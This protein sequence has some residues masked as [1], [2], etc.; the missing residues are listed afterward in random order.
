M[1]LLVTLVLGIGLAACSSHPGALSDGGGT[2]GGS[3]GATNPP[4]GGVY[5][6]EHVIVVV[7]EN[8]TFD[9]YFGTFPGAE[10][11]TM[12]QTSTGPVAVGRPPLQMTRD[13]CH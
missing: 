13:L 10:G 9:N 6:I 11:T 7:K 3:T 5:P 12:A 4:P 1:K 2:G 8:H